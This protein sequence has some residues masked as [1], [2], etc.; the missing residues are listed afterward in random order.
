VNESMGIPDPLPLPPRVDAII[1]GAHVITMDP[2]LGELAGADVRIRNGVIVEVGHGLRGS[3]EVI[4]G[5]G[6]AL[7]P[8]LVDTHWHLWNT[9]LRGT[10]SDRPGRDYFTVKRTLAP[11]YRVEDF[12]WAA[13]LA[14]AEAAFSGITTVHNWDHN[15]R[16]PDD[17]DANI[18]GHLDSGLRGRFSYGPRDQCLPGE[19][20]DVADVRR[21]VSEW[22]PDRT[23]GRISLG[24]AVR[25]PY[26]TGP[27]VY[28]E[29]WGTAR[30]LALP[31]TMHCDRCLREADCRRCGI[32]R[33]GELGLLGPDLQMVHAV[34]ATPEDIK[35]LADSGTHVS[36]SPLTEMRTMGFPKLTELLEAGILVSL[37]IDTT[38]IP[39][40]ADLFGQMRAILS[41]EMARTGSPILTP[42]RVLEMATSDG[43]RDLG[44]DDRVGSITPGKRADLILV[45][46]LDLNL[47]P[48]TDPLGLIVLAAQ[49]GNVD[50][51]I[52]DG[53]IL[54]R[55]GKLQA[56]DVDE[57]AAKAVESLNR[58]LS[59]AGW[60]DDLRL[61]PGAR[62]MASSLGGTS[63]GTAVTG[64]GGESE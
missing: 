45:R 46:M 41:V 15:V 23:D 10:I 12:Y 24:M 40:N 18:R 39:T 21:M 27:E 2:A 6:M 36:L 61:P 14:L 25:G 31:L 53:R 1:T 20:M 44:L 11:H 29:E 35:A 54:K 47:A 59:V 30:E 22:A 4:S 57:V 7:L 50:T 26:R 8:G 19:L 48:G 51:V 55:D 17:A 42:R 5:T 62:G 43:A 13:R 32:T 9:L 33:L 38:A 3:D 16:S 56:V 49:P 60:G 63:G 64:P 34:H 28:E 58:M 52:A 37:S